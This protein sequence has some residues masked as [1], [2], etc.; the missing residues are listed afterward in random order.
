M[1]LLIFPLLAVFYAKHSIAGTL[2]IVD[3]GSQCMIW[4]NDNHGCTG[5][6]TPFSLPNGEDCSKLGGK[7]KGESQNLPM[8]SV[9]ACTTAKGLPAVWILLEKTGRIT[10]FNKQGNISA[11][12]MSDGLKVGSMCEAV[13]PEVLRAST[14]H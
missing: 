8:V 1:R 6:S 12:T 7:T 9:E 13:D 4:S 11:C 14:L 2:S 10:F 5:H 3:V